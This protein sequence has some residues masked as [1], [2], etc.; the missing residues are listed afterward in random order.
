MAKGVFC[1]YWGMPTISRKMVGRG[2]GGQSM[3][4]ISKNKLKN[5]GQHP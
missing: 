4:L 3:W 1:F 5:Y 2:G